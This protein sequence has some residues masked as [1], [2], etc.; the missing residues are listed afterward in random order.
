MTFSIVVETE[1]LAKSDLARLEACLASIAR[2]SLDIRRA[3]DVVL[4]NSGQLD[5]ASL[6]GLRARFP[7][8]RVHTSPRPLHY[9]DAKMLGARLTK[10]EV[11][12]FADADMEYAREWLEAH[13]RAFEQPDVSF[14]S[15]ETYVD[16]RGPYTFSVAT[17]WFFAV[18]YGRRTPA[19]LIANNAA[20][21]RPVLLAMPFPSGLPLYRA[22][23]VLHGAS[24]R[25]QGRKIAQVPAR[26]THAP[27][28][29]PLG[30]ALRF[31]VS[32]SDSVLMSCYVVDPNGAISCR[33][34]FGRRLAGW[35]R[36][37]ARKVGAS[38]LRTSHAL[39][40]RPGRAVLLPLSVPISIAAL[41]VFAVGGLTAVIGSQTCYRWMSLFEADATPARPIDTSSAPR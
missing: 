12:I 39:A 18:R 26:G 6:A 23:I 38:T 9:Y 34:T 35:L 21:R 1:N 25:R 15:G 33:P 30:W 17:T 19:S 20:A 4:V 7:W 27:P 14:T 37:V 24:I 13:L 11:V 2:Q 31:A 22:Q 36:A 16:I 32:G 28:A 10:G 29:T 41:L 8:I 5:D 3:T 40:D